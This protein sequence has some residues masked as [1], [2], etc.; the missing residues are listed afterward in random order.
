[1][2]YWLAVG[3]LVLVG[4]AVLVSLAVFAPAMLMI[5]VGTLILV[6]ITLTAIAIVDGGALVMARKRLTANKLDQLSL[7][8]SS[9]LESSNAQGILDPKDFETLQSAVVIADKYASE[10]RFVEVRAIDSAKEIAHETQRKS[11]REGRERIGRAFDDAEVRP[12]I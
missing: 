12:T 9:I 1:M 7:Q 2:L 11:I 6:G 4:G 10:L 8:L 5:L 3:W